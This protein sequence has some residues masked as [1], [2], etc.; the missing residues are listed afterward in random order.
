MR[1]LS[2]GMRDEPGN[3]SLAVMHSYTQTLGAKLMSSFNHSYQ[4]MDTALSGGKLG[5]EQSPCMPTLHFPECQI[6][7][8]AQQHSSCLQS[9]GDDT[10]RRR[11]R[12]RM[13][14]KNRYLLLELMW[15]DGKLEENMQESI[16]QTAIRES[17]G[18]AFGDYGL[19]LASGALQVKFYN[20]LTGLCVLRCARDQLQEAS[21]GSHD[22][23]LDAKLHLISACARQFSLSML[24]DACI[25]VA[26]V[27]INSH[28]K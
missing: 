7:H 25:L 17:V 12:Q 18:A 24:L 23:T 19:A 5:A 27:G 10:H 26:G 2:H 16:I 22:A 14:L 15:K 11:T 3:P 21:M 20:P 13:R 4:C 6:G 28:Y 9:R 8:V 1:S